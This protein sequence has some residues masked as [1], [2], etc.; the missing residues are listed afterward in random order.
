M[1]AR[2]VPALLK[3]HVGDEISYHSGAV[4]R[5]DILVTVVWYGKF[6]LAQKAIV[7]NFLLSLTATP[8]PP[9]ATTPSAE[10]LWSTI[11]AVVLAS[12]SR[13]RRPMGGRERSGGRQSAGVGGAREELTCGSHV[14]LLFSRDPIATFLSLAFLSMALSSLSSHVSECPS[15]HRWQAGSSHSQQ[16]HNLRSTSPSGVVL[17]DASLLEYAARPINHGPPRSYW[18][19]STTG[20]T[21]ATTLGPGPTQPKRLV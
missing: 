11:A 3:S 14:L 7:V 16:A 6:K 19:C 4:L 2:R 5:G 21:G 12:G 10:K 8:P 18:A 20:S 1:A 17:L 15:E 13:A 9:N